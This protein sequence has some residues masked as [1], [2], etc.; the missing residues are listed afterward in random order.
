M[1]LAD[2]LAQMHADCDEAFAQPAVFRPAAGGAFPCSVEVFQPEPIFG[3]EA[4]T[5]AAEI[6]LRVV[7]A[8]LPYAPRKDD[9]FEVGD[10]DL[11]V[12]EKPA[13]EDD[14]GLR[15]TIKAAKLRQ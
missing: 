6:L 7:K 12:L 9:V 5:A 4:K 13:T 2:D 3:N 10:V 1:S 15:W 11:R 8:S 14:D